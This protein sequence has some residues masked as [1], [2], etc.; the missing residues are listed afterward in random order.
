MLT[1]QAADG[2]GLEGVRIQRAQGGLRALGRLVRPGFTASYR[3]I[4][5]DDDIVQR[6]S[7]TSATAARERHLTLNRRE[8]GL[9]LADSGSGSTRPA[10][11]GALDV[12]VEFS[13]LYNSLPI[14]RLG[15]HR[16]PGDENV[17]MVFVPLPDL[18]PRL[19]TQRYY[20]ISPLADGRAVVGFSW[21]EFEAELDVDV[22]GFVVQYPQIA[23]LVAAT[24]IPR[25]ASRAAPA[26]AS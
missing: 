4:V 19:V 12:D 8:D 2:I 10:F 20:T 26:A 23:T 25:P 18:E 1:W 22:N 17:P 3:L 16:E 24:E 7:L 11:D 6:V 15:L 21:D 5:G 14:R 13:A 9:W